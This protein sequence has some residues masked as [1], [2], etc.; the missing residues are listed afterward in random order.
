MKIDLP[1][2]SNARD[3]GGMPTKFGTIKKDKL[4]R[5]GILN[6]L[7]DDDVAILKQHR[8]ERV[9]DLRTD[10]ETTNDPDVL[11]E[12][13]QHIY[14]PII[15]SVT[16]GISFE[17]LDGPTMATRL[18]GGLERMRNKGEDYPTHMRAVYARYVRDEFARGGYGRFLKT[19]ANDPVNG[20]TLWHCT[21][22]KDRCGTSALLLE[23]CLGVSEE[24]IY[25]DFMESNVQT[26]NNTNSILN[27]VKPYVTPDKV[28]LIQAM[29]MVQPYY[30][31]AYF[32]EMNKLFGGIDG[33]IAACGVT[34]SDIENLRKNY[35]E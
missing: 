28:D 10:M 34:S 33:F 7:T 24:Q 2:V 25:D 31:E 20:A 3:L 18:E 9:I 35:L 15:R 11:I 22:G 26:V 27:R 12:G 14:I 23:Y 1:N 30:L 4:L 13:V 29:L 16:F 5:S 8:L 17:S 21:M 19:L 6:R 32:D